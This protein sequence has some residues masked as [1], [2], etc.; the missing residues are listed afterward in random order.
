MG[1]KPFAVIGPLLLGFAICI[2]G[3][4]V[5]GC[6]I[7]FVYLHH[8]PLPITLYTLWAIIVLFN[9]FYN[10]FNAVFTNP[11]RVDDDEVLMSL[12]GSDESEANTP[13]CQK[14]NHRKPP[15]AHHCKVCNSCVLLMDHHCPWINNCVGYFNRRFFVLFLFWT[16]VG[17]VS[18]F[19]LVFEHVVKLLSKSPLPPNQPFPTW[20]VLGS[21]FYATGLAFAVNFLFG[22][23]LYL[24]GSG[25]TSIEWSA[26]KR[27]KSQAKANGQVFHNAWDLGW[28][29]N[30]RDVFGDKHWIFWALPSRQKPKGNGIN[31]ETVSY[32]FPSQV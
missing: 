21:W 4:F 9:L 17:L 19:V 13:V 24:I 29:A 23:N 32:K 12:K 3:V 30:C 8:S 15:R 26:N 16:G 10:Y 2:I 11:G 22:I 20:L 7:E 14:C 31:Y 1:G 6:T 25:Q 18:Y 28:K 27:L 5:V